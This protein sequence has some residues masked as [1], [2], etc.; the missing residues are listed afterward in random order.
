[1]A[2]A[3]NHLS[4]MGDDGVAYCLSEV[5]QNL[6]AYLKTTDAVLRDVCVQLL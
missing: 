2:L 1:M 4:Y 5:T 3:D 6:E